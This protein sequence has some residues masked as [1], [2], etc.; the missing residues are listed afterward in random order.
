M[1]WWDVQFLHH[2]HFASHMFWKI[3]RVIAIYKPRTFKIHFQNLNLDLMPIYCLIKISDM[4]DQNSTQAN[5]LKF[6]W[7]IIQWNF[8]FFITKFT[9]YCSHLNKC[10]HLTMYVHSCQSILDSPHANIFCI[11]ILNYVTQY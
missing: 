1:E 11:Q 10:N 2:I 4:F 6:L 5:A 3:I 9:P 8:C 7:I